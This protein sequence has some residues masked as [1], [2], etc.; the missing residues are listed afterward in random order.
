MARVSRGNAAEAGCPGLPCCP[1]QLATHTAPLPLIFSPEYCTALPLGW[2]F[3]QRALAVFPQLTMPLQNLR[4]AV[5]W[6][7]AAAATSGQHYS[8]GKQPCPHCWALGNHYIKLCLTPHALQV[9]KVVLQLRPAVW[10]APAGDL[11]LPAGRPCPRATQLM[12][13]M[14]CT[15]LNWA[16]RPGTCGA[17]CVAAGSSAPRAPAPASFSLLAYP[18]FAAGAE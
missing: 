17:A 10:A 4:Q 13:R 12:R 14:P 15:A 5:R 9:A 16:T 6:E 18:K 2:I 7:G 3:D 8:A 11:A 1:A